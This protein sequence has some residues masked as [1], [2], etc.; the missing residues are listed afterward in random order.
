ME[1]WAH[2]T[3]FRT[4]MELRTAGPLA[5]IS[6]CRNVRRYSMENVKISLALNLEYESKEVIFH[7]R[8]IYFCPAVQDRTNE[9]DRFYWY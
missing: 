2:F 8:I 3:W 5:L 7:K 4:K 9:D 1:R 6:S